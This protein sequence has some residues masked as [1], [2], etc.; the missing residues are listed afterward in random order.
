[1]RDIEGSNNDAIR[2]ITEYFESF[3]GESEFVLSE[4]VS[5]E[6]Q[7]DVHPIPP[8]DDDPY[9]TLFTTGMSGLPMNVPPEAAESEDAP[10]VSLLQYAELMLRL[11]PDWPIRELANEE[12]ADMYWPIG[13]LKRVARL[14]K[15]SDSWLGVG[16]TVQLSEPHEEAKSGG[17]SGILVMPALGPDEFGLI[18]TS[19]GRLINVYSALVLYRDELDFKLKHGLDALLDKLG[20]TEL[21]DMIVPGRRS[22]VAK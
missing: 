10:D 4:I 8:T 3:L 20:A 15:D 13:W 18:E 11:P 16:H 21:T 19:D 6:L 17:F 5:D 7:I 14:P 1:M 2:E 9:W 22:L 12:R